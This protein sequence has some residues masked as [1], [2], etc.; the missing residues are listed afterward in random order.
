VNFKL[1][2]IVLKSTMFFSINEDRIYWHKKHLMC[3]QTL[4]LPTD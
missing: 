3:V 2:V 4:R 1:D